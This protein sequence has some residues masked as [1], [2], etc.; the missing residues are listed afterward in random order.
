MTPQGVTADIDDGI[1]D[2][3]IDGAL[4]GG[5]VPDGRALER[6]DAPVIARVAAVQAFPVKSMDAAPAGRI[7]LAESGVVGDRGHA[8]HEI[9]ENGEPGEML[10]AAELPR[11]RWVVAG[12]EPDGTV[13]LAVPGSDDALTGPAADRALSAWLDRPLRVV[14]VEPG[15]QL[16]APVHL[17][18]RQALEAADRG[19]HEAADCACSLDE[20]RANLVLDVEPSGQ[21][22]STIPERAGSARPCASGMRCSGS[23]ATPTTASGST[24]RCW[25]RGLSSPGTTSGWPTSR[26]CTRTCSRSPSTSTSRSPS[27]ESNRSSR[28]AAALPRGTAGISPPGWRVRSVTSQVR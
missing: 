24:P 23:S 19:E 28:T 12:L 16:E 25:S 9:G 6:G 21:P 3:E 13:S 20:P 14:A 15:S 26:T 4:A 22:A 7:E 8:V 1:A 5:E 10:T 2:D 17:V 27:P 11:L 18:T